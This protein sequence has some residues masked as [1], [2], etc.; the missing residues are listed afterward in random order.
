MDCD[1]LNKDEYRCHIVHGSVRSP[2]W[3]KQ[4]G[5]EFIVNEVSIYANPAKSPFIT[6]NPIHLNPTSDVGSRN[7]QE[8]DF[9]RLSVWFDKDPEVICQIGEAEIDYSA[10][11]FMT[12]GYKT[13]WQ[14][15]LCDTRRQYSRLVTNI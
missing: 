12:M 4:E 2:S 9:A 10:D 11:G 3:G 8:S 13:K 7:R 1:I 15:L 6:Q 5:N 14:K